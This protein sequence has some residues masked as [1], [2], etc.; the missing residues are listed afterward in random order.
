SRTYFFFFS[1]H[2]ACIRVSENSIQFSFRLSHSPGRWP[3][4]V[5]STHASSLPQIMT[6]TPYTAAS[7]VPHLSSLTHCLYI[8]YQSYGFPHP[9]GK[10]LSCSPYRLHMPRLYHKKA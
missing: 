5:L 9:S 6:H 7:P 3:F 10:Q 8:L 4:M 1:S 2:F